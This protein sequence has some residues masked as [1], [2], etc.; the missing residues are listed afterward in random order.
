MMHDYSELSGFIVV[1]LRAWAEEAW[2]KHINSEEG[3]LSG[4]YAD[5]S[6]EHE[7]FVH[8]A[9]WR[10]Y[11]EFRDNFAIYFLTRLA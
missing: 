3:E 9:I 7:R 10:M 11:R 4:H 1:Q 5:D 2:L 8:A 6:V